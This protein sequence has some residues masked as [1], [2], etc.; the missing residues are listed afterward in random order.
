MSNEKEAKELFYKLTE[1]NIKSCSQLQSGTT[2]DVFLI[3]DAYVLKI[4][5]GFRQPFLDLDNEYNILAQLSNNKNI[6]KAIYFDYEKPYRLTK[7]VHGARAVNNT[8]SDY[9]IIL[10]AKALKK[11]HRTQDIACNLFEPFIRLDEYKKQA[12]KKLDQHYEKK[13]LSRVKELYEDEKLALCHN[14]LVRGN[15]LFKFDSLVLIDFEFAGKNIIYFDL[16]S[17][18]SENNLNETQSQ[19]FLKTYFGA[20][21]NKKKEKNVRLMI[22]FNDI[23]WYYW[24]LMMFNNTSNDIF[25]DIADEKL[26]RIKKH[27]EDKLF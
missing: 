13:I 20:N 1:R 4:N 14:D 12:K 11:L 7:F 5:K 10:T 25:E 22:E 6:E 21:L 17:F 19:L 27:Q 16:A 15:L 24:S 2:S 18:I 23:L 8:Y 9:Q 26:L 3:N